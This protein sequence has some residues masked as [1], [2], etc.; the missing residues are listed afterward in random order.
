MKSVI[1]YIW[2]D[3]N[4]NFRSKARTLQLS[5][6]EKET[7]ELLTEIP[8]WNYDGSSTG[9]ATGKD[10][11]ITLVPVFLVHCPF[12]GKPHFVVL[13]ETVDRK[14]DPLPNNHRR[15]AKSIFDQNLELEPWYGL[16]QEYYMLAWNPTSDRVEPLGFDLARTQGQY[17]CS[18]GSGNAYGRE[19]ANSHL[20][21]CLVAG[22]DISGINAEVAPG[23]WEFQI[24]PTTGIN[25]G[26]QLLMARYFLVLVG[27]KFHTEISFHP[28]PEIIRHGHW[29]GSGCH[30]N[31]STKPMRDLKASDYNGLHHISIAV[32][33]LEK[34]HTLHMEHY[35]IDNRMRMTGE[36]ETASYDVFTAGRADRGASVRIPNT[37]VQDK[38][39]YFEDR[40]PA[41]N[42]DPYLVTALI[43]STCCDIPLGDLEITQKPL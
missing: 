9:Q 42:C 4:S 35:G 10:S 40:R 21:A 28:K 39:G 18:V 38:Y 5:S 17:Y 15:W 6:H 12:R 34:L 11:E 27:E 13:C 23:Q 19:I 20:K 41:S 36:C 43:F 8:N 24:G 16:E 14:G 31:F 33:K 7:S 25:A 26:D 2:L 22:L 37:T 1:E 3:S 30:C 32:K 29:N